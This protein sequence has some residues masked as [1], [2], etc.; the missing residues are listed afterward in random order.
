MLVR[1]AGQMLSGEVMVGVFHSK[2]D[3]SATDPS[4]CSRVT[5]YG[6]LITRLS[7]RLMARCTCS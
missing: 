4:F 1:S 2:S 7:A 6:R 3:T 5:Y